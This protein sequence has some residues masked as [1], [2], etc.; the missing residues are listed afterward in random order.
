[1]TVTTL[2]RV[3]SAALTRDLETL[4]GINES[5]PGVTRLAYTSLERRAHEY[6][7]G[8]LERLGLIV[9]TD[10][11][12]NTIAE[13]PGTLEGRAAAI[14]TGSHLDTV[15]K[16]GR[17]DGVAGVIAAM[18][19]ARLAIVT[20]EPRSRPWRFVVF[21]G[22]EG[23][24]F[25]QACNGSRMA[26]GL[27]NACDLQ[28]LRDAAGISL[29]DAMLAVGLE[30]DG[31]DQGCWNPD[32]WHAFIELHIEQGT[33]LER[34]EGRLGVV[35]IV[36]GSTRIAVRV[37]GQATHS[38]GTPMS[39]RHDALVTA[40]ECVLTGDRI[41]SDLFHQGTRV[42]V[43]RFNVY[44]GSITTIPGVVEFTVD[45]RDIDGDRQRATVDEIVKACR[46][47]SEF[48]G[49]SVQTELLADTSPVR[50]SESVGE[51]L[52]AAIDESGSGCLVL[53][54]GASHD[55]QQISHIVPSGM[56]F[57]PSR[58]GLSHVPEEFTSTDD[59]VRGTAA[60]YA[61]MRRLDSRQ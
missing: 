4:A 18:E 39:D 43:G 33:V 57:V 40:A 50:L 19:V 49:T 2:P 21:A 47:V 60:L 7:A 58:G 48:R 12:G 24:R 9:W 42:T 52:C 8:R 46:R 16:G 53:T 11:A 10:A 54:S 28:G 55:T 1:M 56:I 5:G 3:D 20:R 61:A 31:I 51:L 30:P 34:N 41:A 14:G 35:D 15:P 26:V 6:F 23:A 36:S 13:L 44:P 25:G 27:T 45:V 32:E 17:F 59:L 37:R 22:E 38:G 29:R